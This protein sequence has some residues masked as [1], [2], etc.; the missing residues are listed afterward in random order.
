MKAIY[1][2]HDIWIIFCLSLSL[3]LSTSAEIYIE[4]ISNSQSI[5]CHVSVWK[6]MISLLNEKC[7][8]EKR[9]FYHRHFT[10]LPRCVFSCWGFFFVSLKYR[11]S[12]I[13]ITRSEFSE[14]E[15]RNKNSKFRKL[16][17]GFCGRRLYTHTHTVGC[18]HLA[19]GVASFYRSNNLCMQKL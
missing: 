6:N 13:S 4:N 3:T 11:K 15:F 9:Y 8:V 14:Y 5:R 1:S 18:M 7:Y 10:L 2:I 17:C 16:F 12:A 19:C